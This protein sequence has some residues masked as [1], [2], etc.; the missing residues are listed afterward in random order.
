MCLGL[1]MRL[2]QRLAVI[3]VPPIYTYVQRYFSGSA[4]FAKAAWMSDFKIRELWSA[5]SRSRRR[6][7]TPRISSCQRQLWFVSVKA[8]RMCPMRS[9]NLGTA[10]N[11]RFTTAIDQRHAE[12]PE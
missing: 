2:P 7:G 1:R 8:F 12:L 6:K 5:L 3:A 4:S 10:R 11:V 9:A